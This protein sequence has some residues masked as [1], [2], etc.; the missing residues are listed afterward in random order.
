[1]KVLVTGATGLIGK[2]LCAELAR[3]GHTI[4]VLSRST[5]KAESLRFPCEIIAWD[6][7][8]EPGGEIWRDVDALIHLAGEPITK[9]WSDEQKARLFESRVTTTRLLRQSMEKQPTGK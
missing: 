6:F 1:M 2:A 7:T 8:S 9:R 4:R 3:K 5:T